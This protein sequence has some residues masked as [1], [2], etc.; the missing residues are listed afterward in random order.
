MAGRVGE[1]IGY[2]M[3]SCLQLQSQGKRATGTHSQLTNRQHLQTESSDNIYK[4]TA[5]Q[6]LNACKPL[7]VNLT[8]RKLLAAHLVAK[9]QHVCP[10]SKVKKGKKAIHELGVKSFGRMCAL[11][12]GSP[13]NT[14]KP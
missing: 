6:Q 11:D 14:E 4:I 12:R 5:M 3:C 7:P 9:R 1:V 2:W 8:T 10:N 13:T